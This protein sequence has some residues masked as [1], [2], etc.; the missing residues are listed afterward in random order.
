MKKYLAIQQLIC[1]QSLG[2]KIQKHWTLVY[3][4]STT[5]NAKHAEKQK[6]AL[7]NLVRY[8]SNNWKN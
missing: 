7:A 8:A 1:D 6:G 2:V 5:K 4:K 3:N